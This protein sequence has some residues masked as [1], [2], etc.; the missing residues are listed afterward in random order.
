[1][2]YLQTQRFSECYLRQ[3]WHDVDIRQP[4]LE[5]RTAVG[6]ASSGNGKRQW[7]TY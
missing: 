7:K 5:S 4:E 6:K 2:N 3:S 1:V